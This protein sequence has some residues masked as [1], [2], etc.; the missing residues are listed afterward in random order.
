M[1]EP[2]Y[3]KVAMILEKQIKNGEYKIKEKLPSEREL[4]VMYNVSR[5]T[6][7]QAIIYLE[8]KDLVYRERSSGT[9]VQAPSIQQNNIK[10]FTET[11][12]DLGYEVHT[13]ILEFCTVHS[14]SS[15]CKEMELP[16]S[17][18]FYKIKRLRF[19][20]QI[21][22]ALEIL[23]IPKNYLKGLEQH[24]LENSFY[25]VLEEYYGLN[26]SRVSY[27]MEAIVAN[28]VYT[29]L[30]LI[31]KG[32]ALLKVS[33]VSFDNNDRKLIYEESFYRSD[34]YNYHID[35]NNQ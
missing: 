16:I 5:M 13:N 24:N 23:Y 18:S 12:G 25:N 33:G 11:V 27:K 6:A 19:G 7:R 28:P 34:L 29:K 3:L 4:A 2:V 17:T 26:I 30:L 35:I 32:T 14:V 15:I 9:Y 22:M 1:K 8:E 21:P 20:N 10:S 31:K